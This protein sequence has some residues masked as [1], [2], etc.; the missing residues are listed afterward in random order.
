MVS[1]NNIN[2][3]TSA[4]RK[5]DQLYYYYSIYQLY[6][7][8]SCIGQVKLQGD[9]EDVKLGWL[10]ERGGLEGFKWRFSRSTLSIPKNGAKKVNLTLET[11]NILS[12]W[13]LKHWLHPY[14]LL[15]TS[16]INSQSES[17]FFHFSLSIGCMLNYKH[18]RE[19]VRV[20]YSTVLSFITIGYMRNY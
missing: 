3:C 11:S 13:L 5:S 9:F 17:W 18:I 20:Q 19:Q 2:N 6:I 1:V 16:R 7:I 10:H 14:F 15:D 8:Y 4:R 12:H